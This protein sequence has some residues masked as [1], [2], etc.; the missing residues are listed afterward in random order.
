MASVKNEQMFA[1]L[2]KETGKKIQQAVKQGEGKNLVAQT[3]ARE[4]FEKYFAESGDMAA[5][6]S[7]IAR[8]ILLG[9]F[10]AAEKLEWSLEKAI[11]PLAQGLM[12][13]IYKNCHDYTESSIVLIKAAIQ[14]ST[15]VTD[16]VVPLGTK[17]LQ[18]I[19]EGGEEVEADMPDL[20]KKVTRAATKAA[21]GAPKKEMKDLENILMGLLE[22][23]CS[24]R[25]DGVVWK[26]KTK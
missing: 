18:T 16:E 12:A 24:L 11:V 9:A 17:V 26:K 6:G 10:R 15:L 1:A 7:K 5:D 20:L 19:I 14:S 23:K 4:Q 21:K 25:A 3:I 2:E 8:R 22:G 13:G